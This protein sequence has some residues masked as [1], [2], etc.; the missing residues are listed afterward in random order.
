MTNNNPD[1]YEQG[2]VR[3]EWDDIGEGVSGD[4]NDNDPDDIALLRF[5]FATRNSAGEWE[6]LENGSY[7]TRFPVDSTPQ[8]RAQALELLMDRAYDDILAGNYKRTIE[9]LSWIEPGWL[10]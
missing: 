4:Y 10:K 1:A 8:Q 3:V 2:D 7:C 9:E 5:Y 6:D